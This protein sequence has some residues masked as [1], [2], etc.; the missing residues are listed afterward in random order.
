MVPVVPSSAS[1]PKT[2]TKTKASLVTKRKVSSSHTASPKAQRKK[3]KV[4]LP[5]RQ[6]EDSPQL[7]DPSIHVFSDPPLERSRPRQDAAAESWAK[8]VPSLIYPTMR[9]LAQWEGVAGSEGAVG[10]VCQS[11]CARKV[12]TVYVLDFK[13]IVS[14]SPT[15]E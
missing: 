13:G 9:W 15:D 10:A 12:N 4:T 7:E 2:K 3:Q 1:K 5:E 11:N 14:G 8:L 6:D